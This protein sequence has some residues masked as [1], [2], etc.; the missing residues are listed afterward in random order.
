MNG[1]HAATADAVAENHELAR[2]TAGELTA[3]ASDLRAGSADAGTLGKSDEALCSVVDDERTLVAAIAEQLTEL[4]A[5]Q[6]DGMDAFT[7][8]LFGR[9]GAGKS[10]LLEALSAGD[11]GSI[12]PGDSDW[13][14][15]VRP[16][17]WESCRVIDTPGVQ[18]WG[19]TTE[20]RELEERARAALVSA[21]IVL[22]CFDTQH[23]QAGEF[24]KVAE[25]IAEFGKP[26]IAV[27][28]VRLPN[29]R[30]PTRVPR[31]AVRWRLS[32]TVAEHAQH[33]REELAAIGIHE[34]PLVAL[35]TQRAVYA[36]A[37]EPIQVPAPQAR[38]LRR[39]RAEV[40]P[41]TLLDW[42]NL[43]L[44]EQ[45]LVAAI[46]SGAGKLRRGMLVRQLVGRLEL[47]AQQ[48]ITQV[49]QPARYIVEQTEH[50]IEQMLG[51]LGAPE[52]YTGSTTGDAGGDLAASRAVVERIHE[53][54]RVRGSGLEAPPT[55]S[56]YRYAQNRV[57]ASLA[58]LRR[59]AA[60]RA[61]HLVNDAMRHQT[62]I[63][64]TAFHSQ[65][66]DLAEIER[67]TS[68][69]VGELTE[70]LQAKVGLTADDVLADLR[71]VPPSTVTVDGAAGRNMQ[72]AGNAAGAGLAIASGVAGAVTAGAL[73]G[74][75]A[76]STLGVV[77]AA[78]IWNPIGWTL[79]IGGIAAGLTG[80]RI[81]KWLHRRGARRREEELSRTRG[82]ARKA[83]ADTFDGL[84]DDMVA[85]FVGAARRAVV[86]RLGVVVDQ[87]LLLR[88]IIVT[89]ADHQS[90]LQSVAERQ[91]L[92]VRSGDSAAVLL[93]NAVR[94]CEGAAQAVPFGRS[95][96]LGE[97]WCDDPAGLIGSS[98]APV[99]RPA[100]T[101]GGPLGDQVADRLR[102]VLAEAAA[103]P[104]P[105]VGTDWLS[106]LTDLLADD[107]RARP[108]LD[109]LTALAA[110]RCPRVLL[111][112]DYNVGKSSFIKRL[113]VD[114][115]Q[116]APE[117]L[118]V[119]G[120]P[121]TAAVHS[122]D[123]LG[124]RLIDT[125]GLQSGVTGHSELAQ[126]QLPDAALVVYML[127]ATGV[128]GDRAGLDRV[129]RGDPEHGIVP[130]LDR[131]IFVVN[132]A[133]ELSIN[134]FDDEDAFAQVLRRKENELRDALA[135]TGALPGDGVPA[136]RILF[137]ASDPGGQVG[138]D[139][140]VTAADFDPFRRW[141][142][143][144]EVRAA[145][146]ELSAE[147]WDNS[148]DVT[149]L[150]GG[151]ARLGT[152]AAGYRA[153]AEELRA[154]ITQLD[155]LRDDLTEIGRAA[156]SIEQYARASVTT[157]VGNAIDQLV[158]AALA[159]RD[160]PTR[161]A[162]L[163]RVVEFWTDTEVGQAVDEWAA[164]VQRRVEDWRRESAIRLQRR[165]ASSAF[166]RTVRSVDGLVRT[167]F[168]TRTEQR[169]LI[170]DGSS[171]LS[172]MLGMVNRMRQ[173]QVLKTGAAETLRWFSAASTATNSSSRLIN[174]TRGFLASRVAGQEATRIARVGGRANVALS[175]AFTVADLAFIVRD[176]KADRRREEQFQETLDE[177]NDQAQRWARGVADTIRR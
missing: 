132:R 154:D 135:T 18:G 165:L 153:D 169:K 171:A 110:D 19:R 68:G 59:A 13:T 120:A 65:V 127:G 167:Q 117:N 52:N 73:L 100:R 24:R 72:W 58:E 174:V 30:F 152:L 172:T 80:P 34:I 79:A 35:H 115:G 69:L 161:E 91:R 138:D 1:L 140:S 49:E 32:R 176:H 87:A 124:L 149:V 112:G 9:T 21:D 134:P 168:P 133:D 37:T 67:A 48:L 22:L 109:E 151:L 71:T 85:W 96:W 92:Q 28:N 131:T 27:L 11:G 94:V 116:T 74:A 145:F 62:Q 15:A 54:E 97:T 136:E 95:L 144:D 113:L 84:R 16:V 129:L 160:E 175:V 45:L 156:E 177:L 82:A 147:L 53:L 46:E 20:R 119:R 42:S 128:V 150:H 164:D 125:P 50:G 101:G 137:V 99:E 63:D 29:W 86:E 2:Q 162:I 4:A 6:V 26:A 75:A 38:S 14:T 39:L 81:R 51:V 61:E 104:R 126:A 60:D 103:R 166:Q 23:Q 55:G 98:A 114:D 170:K 78:N 146:E 17:T 25:W 142:G 33:I 10:S 148:A 43:P 102:R 89:A 7:I 70:Y 3:L 90:T 76:S 123:W 47:A 173:A 143:M 8:A 111:Y 88:R 158:E 44:L 157:V 121:E 5:E 108:M 139:R 130:K 163:G 159:T 118:T 141:D 66:F 36:R 107:P 56:A 31:S 93:G 40:G 41:A 64:A 122:F 12:S 83:V 57:D 155:R 106:L 77:A 105:G